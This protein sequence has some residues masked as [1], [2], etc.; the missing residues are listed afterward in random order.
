MKLETAQ[1]LERA[2]FDVGVE[3]E[4]RESYSGRGMFGDTTAAVE[5]AH[6]RDLLVAVAQAALDADD[7]AGEDA[8]LLEELH[9]LRF[10]DMGLGHVAY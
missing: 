4:A 6:W 5:F 9:R 7:E 3:V 10:D 2:A 1:A 8:E